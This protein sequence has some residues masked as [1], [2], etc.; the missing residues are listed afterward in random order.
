MKAILR[1]PTEQYAFIE[2]QIESD[3]L[4][5]IKE[6]YD[7]LKQSVKPQEGIPTKDFNAFIDRQM[8]GE[9]NHV[10]EYMSMSDWQKSVVQELK[11]AIKRA[12]AKNK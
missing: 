11:K 6:I 4:N 7:E 8:H 9:T 10:E 5:S 12:E 1:V 2:L 3:S